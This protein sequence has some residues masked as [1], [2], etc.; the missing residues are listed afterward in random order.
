[1]LG[2][3]NDV[4]RML[5]LV[6]LTGRYSDLRKGLS[7]LKTSLGNVEAYVYEFKLDA[8]WLLQNVKTVTEIELQ[9]HTVYKDAVAALLYGLG[10]V[11]ING[12]ATEVP[13]VPINQRTTGVLQASVAQSLGMSTGV[14]VTIIK[15]IGGYRADILGVGRGGVILMGEVK[16]VKD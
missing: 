13:I 8:G 1:V 12:I 2:V 9:P 15:Q 14:D 16:S 11:E 6:A 4:G 7:T 3:Y 5:M 10:Y